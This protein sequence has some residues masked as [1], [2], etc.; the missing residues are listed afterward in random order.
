MNLVPT[1][2]GL[3]SRVTSGVRQLLPMPRRKPGARAVDGGGGS[4]ILCD[5]ATSALQSSA[6]W[7][8]CRLISQSVGS[9]PGHVFESTPQ[10]KRKATAHPLYQLLTAQ[11]NP[12]MTMTQLVQTL[13][14]HLC[15]YGN[16][17][18]LPELLEG[19]VIALWPVLPSRVRIVI[20]NGA[21][22]YMYSPPHGGTPIPL[23]PFEM[24]HFRVFS[25]DGIVGLSPVDFHRST[26]ELDVVAKQ[27]ASMLYANGGRPVGVLSYQGSLKKEQIDS[28]RASWKQVH[29]GPQN[30]GSVVVLENGAKYDALA[31]PPEQLE[32]VA[33]QKFSVEQIARIFGVPPHLI[34]AQDKPTYASVEQQALEFLQYTLQPIVTSLEKTIR[35]MFLD[36][37]FFYK[38][39]IASFERSDIKTRYA[40]YATAR[41]WGWLSVNDIRELEDLNTIGPEGDIYLQPLNMIDAGQNEPQPQAQAQ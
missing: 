6:F 21:Y 32:F 2:T 22:S 4:V 37:P 23:Q 36:P 40:A 33:Q 19:E 8:C 30:A 7:A 26:L 41:Q 24:A 5:D 11:P 10:G 35:S 29:A 15:L 14:L 18:L 39:Q 34:G 28:I 13:V 12:L 31:I 20:V 27:Y 9:L 1:P 38:F 17:Y 25:V 16:A 3:W